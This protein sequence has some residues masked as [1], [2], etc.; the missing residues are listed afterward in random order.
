MFERFTERARQVVVLAQQEARN[1]ECRYIGTEH[2]LVGLLREEDGLAARVLKKLGVDIVRAAKIVKDLS[3]GT[4]EKIEGQITMTP[5]TKKA[6][7]LAL[8]EALSLG[9]NYIGTE[10]VLLGMLRD[11]QSKAYAILAS[12]FQLTDEQIRNEVIRELSGP[13]AP[14]LRQKV[15]RRISEVASEKIEVRK[16]DELHQLLATAVT[17]GRQ[18]PD[19]PAELV[20]RATIELYA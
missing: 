16:S 7:E 3:D 8:R 20:A 1:N 6:L 15:E 2:L 4:P 13:K 11:D 14:I 10:H 12:D 17:L 18:F 9:H 5:R 19:R